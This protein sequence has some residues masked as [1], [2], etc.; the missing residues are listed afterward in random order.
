[1]RD[2]ILIAIKIVIINF[3]I[4][5]SFLLVELMA[6]GLYPE[7]KNE[8]FSAEL[9]RGIHY[10][11]KADLKGFEGISIRVP[12]SDYKLKSNVPI[13]LLAGDSI[14]H[15]YGLAY[16][17]IYW[18]RFQRL[19]ELAHHDLVQVVSIG[20]MGDN[21]ADLLKKI[22]VQI[23]GNEEREIRS[24]VYQFNYND[25]T[26]FGKREIEDVELGKKVED[27]E[28]DGG[29]TY[30]DWFIR[31][32]KFRYEYINRSVF[33]RVLQNYAGIMIRNNSGNCEERGI[34]ALGFYTWSFGSRPFQKQSDTLWAEFDKDLKKVSM[35]TGK[36]GINFSILISPI[37]YDIDRVGYHPYYNKLNL[38]FSCATINPR[39]RL[40]A[41]AERYDID[42][43]D[44]T[45][46]LREHFEK[47]VKE[48]NFV[49]FYFPGDDN[50]ITPVASAYIAEYM[51]S[52]Y[53]KHALNN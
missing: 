27:M 52:D 20:G 22:E 30:S 12:D 3:V 6:R 40:L 29:I 39:E 21:V 53:I 1:M 36:L 19:I 32:A 43:V 8:T 9:T 50:H 51:F 25:I 31:F 49:P 33:L 47:R 18:N 10:I 14:S 7:L 34:D 5:F 11:G 4:V 23:Q 46:Y 42:V 38:D 17:D 44:P 26:P 15:G 45:E 28:I 13:I 16:E 48:N 2:R 37:L 24:L 41:I 35:I